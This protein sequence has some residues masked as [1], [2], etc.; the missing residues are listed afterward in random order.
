[1][2]K[3]RFKGNHT[4]I[5]QLITLQHKLDIQ[6]DNTIPLENI[7]TE[8]VESY[9][10]RKNVKGIF[11]SLSLEY[12]TCLAFS[13]E[14]AGEISTAI[15]LLSMNTLEYERFFLEIS[16]IWKLKSKGL[17]PLE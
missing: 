5:R 15:F 9:A 2:R 3:S 7:E 4:N 8:I 12:R 17:V 13:K 6:Y 14:E 16:D 1:M 10:L 11:E